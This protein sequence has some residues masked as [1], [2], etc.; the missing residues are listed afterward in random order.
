ML[1]SPGRILID[2]T[3]VCIHEK[4]T[5]RNLKTQGI[6]SYRKINPTNIRISGISNKNIKTNW[7]E[8]C[9]AQFK[10]GQAKPGLAIGPSGLCAFL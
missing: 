3:N 8:L 9:K 2:L 6:I 7:A 5:R 4:R 1:K 10:Q